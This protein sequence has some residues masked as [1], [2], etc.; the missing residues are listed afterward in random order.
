MLSRRRLPANF[1]RT[2][3][4]FCGGVFLSACSS[5]Q[6]VSYTERQAEVPV[7]ARFVIHTASV[8]GA[9]AAKISRM[10][11]E[12]L[13]LRSWQPVLSPEEAEYSWHLGFA[14]QAAGTRLESQPPFF[15]SGLRSR[16]GFGQG[17]FWEPSFLED[18]PELRTRTQYRHELWL[19][20][21]RTL[22]QELIWQG[23]INEISD[24]DQ[25]FVRAPLLL[26]LL[27]RDFPQEKTYA[28]ERID[29]RDPLVQKLRAL[30]PE[31]RNWACPST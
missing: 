18:F 13:R 2:F 29:S 12:S 8:D 3:L 23:S 6:G 21:E 24:C 22:D 10:L 20:L 28:R 25:I 26:A 30:F 17:L 5:L 14:T 7:S 11:E 9:L 19:R 1:L 31:V 15:Y 4:L 27:M 16:Q